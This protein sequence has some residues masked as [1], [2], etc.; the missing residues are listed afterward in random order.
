MRAIIGVL[1]LAGPLTASAQNDDKWLTYRLG[2]TR[3]EGGPTMARL[4]VDAKHETMDV[5]SSFTSIWQFRFRAALDHTSRSDRNTEDSFAEIAFGKRW[6]LGGES[7]P[8]SITD[9]L[10]SAGASYAMIGIYGDGRYESNQTFAEQ[11]G[12]GQL[13]LIF[14]HGKY[15]GPWL[16]VPQWQVAWGMTRAIDSDA[17]EVL[18]V[19]KE[20]H[21]RLDAEA[22]WSVPFSAFSKGGL[23]RLSLNAEF[24]AF[25]TSDL[26]PFLEAIG[27]ASG[28]YFAAGADYRVRLGQANAVFVRWH[29]GRLP[30]QPVLLGAWQVGLRQ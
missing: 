10:A 24:R 11:L 30:A 14:T 8:T 3:P 23:S 9:T 28:R 12:S 17:H 7:I 19:S 26:D 29:R 5:N 13:R 6:A 18:G 27:F 2:L 25:K 20:F 15:S 21:S 1:L 22:F 16:L 4:R